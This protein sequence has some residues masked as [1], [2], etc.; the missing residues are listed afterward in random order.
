MST[1]MNFE[2]GLGGL[3]YTEDFR[4][5][6]LTLAKGCDEGCEAE[7]F[8]MLL[9]QTSDSYVRR[10]L[11]G[12]ERPEDFYSL[13]N[14]RRQGFD[15]R[16]QRTGLGLHWSACASLARSV[17]ALLT[18]ED[19]CSSHF[20]IDWDGTI[21]QLYPLDVATWHGC[22]N[23]RR[24]GVDFAH[25]GY[26]VPTPQGTF[27]DWAGR[28]YSPQLPGPIQLP[29]GVVPVGFRHR[30][31]WAGYSVQM[32]RSLI[33]LARA[34]RH[35]LE[36]AMEGPFLKGHFEVSPQKSD[37]WHFPMRLMEHALVD[38]LDVSSEWTWV[39]EMVAN[40]RQFII[41]HRR[42]GSL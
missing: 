5:L 7:N 20:V 23:K 21:V 14:L 24:V 34:L 39:R 36:F 32:I 1:A 2:L 8:L 31:F 11:K 18:P 27:E 9:W 22:E 25:P 13:E 30:L 29:E 38:N 35:T 6:Y 17:D 4:E 37:P 16:S 3:R 15:L 28:P 41:D 26:L 10:F 40:P 12:R 33:V 42:D 19:R